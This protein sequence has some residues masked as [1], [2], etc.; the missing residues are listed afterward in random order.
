MGYGGPNSN[1]KCIEVVK[2]IQSKIGCTMIDGIVGDETVRKIGEYQKSHG[3]TVD[4]IAG[5]QTRATMSQDVARSWS[6]FPHFQQSEFACKDKCGF[7]NEN[8]KVVEILEDIRSHFGNRPVIITSGCRC[9][10][11]NNKVR[12]CKTEANT[13]LEMPP[14]S[15]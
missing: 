14:I 6:M 13:C 9:V 15:M 11:H 7:M 10:K 2:W 5:V 12:W 3:L 8:L 4:Y 1:T